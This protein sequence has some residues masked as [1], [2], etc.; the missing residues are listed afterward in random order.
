MTTTLPRVALAVRQPWAYAIFHGKDVEN[1]SWKHWKKD[2][3]FRG[4][5]AIL[6][7]KG[8]TQDEYADG[9]DFMAD[10]GVT[11]PPPADLVR[12][13]IIGHVNIVDNVSKSDSPWFVGPG[14]FVLA[15]PVLLNDPIPVDGQLDIFEW[16]L[17]DR[18]VCEPLKWM[19]AWTA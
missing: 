16:K 8:M 7:S 13:A 6:A 5:V 2:W 10:L 14:A 11:C 18:S 3:R 19:R 1:R 9:R 15:D 4:R 17:A 12:G